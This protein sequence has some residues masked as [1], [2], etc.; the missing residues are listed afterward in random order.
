MLARVLSRRPAF[1]RP[2]VR[3]LGLCAAL[4][5]AISAQAVPIAA[6]AVGAGGSFSELTEAQQTTTSG[7]SRGRNRKRIQPVTRPESS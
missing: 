3:S 2:S 1:L 4:V 7:D 5:L 6:A